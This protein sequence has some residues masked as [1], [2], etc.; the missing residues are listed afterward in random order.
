ML[1]AHS[2]RRPGFTLIELLVVIA[3]IAILIALLLPAVQ[4]AREAARRTQCRNNMKQLGLALHNYHDT[5]GTL[6]PGVI[7]PA[8]MFSGNR[9]SYMV[10]LLP[11]L[12]GSAVYN[13]VNF[14][15][16][17]ILWLNQNAVATGASIPALLCP[18]DGGGGS[19]KA[20]GSSQ[21][22]FLTNY[23]GVFSGLQLGDIASTASSKMAA[24]G[25]NR[26]A[27]IRD[28]TDGTSNTMIMAEY[29]TGTPNDFRATAWSD[30][31]AGSY[32]FTEL[33]PN[34][35]SSDRCYPYGNPNACSGCWCENKP[36]ANLPTVNGD[37]GTTDTA[38]SRSRHTGGVQ[39]LLG[40]GAVRFVGDSVDIT[41]WRGLATI[42]GSETLGDF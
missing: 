34:S 10:H 35:K 22:Y 37:G 20:N 38:G 2:R 18:S 9:T 8:G 27:K 3:I 15:V 19:K 17:G 26:G 28:I 39:I 41:L 11:Y 42:A 16:S 13:N 36:L 6:P 4:Q 30:Q 33:G 1:G 31:P 32:L 24:F 5:F 25:T 14:N 23:F 29:L 7:W 40:D 21:F 12:D